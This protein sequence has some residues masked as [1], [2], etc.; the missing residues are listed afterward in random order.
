MPEKQLIML[1]KRKDSQRVHKPHLHK[2]K[3]ALHLFEMRIDGSMATAFG[4]HMD[5]FGGSSELME[6]KARHP[7]RQPPRF[8]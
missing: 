8:A 2:F 1:M 4:P 7:R 3:E 6:H 5:L